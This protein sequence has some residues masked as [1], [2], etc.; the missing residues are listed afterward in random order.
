MSDQHTCPN[1]NVS[2]QTCHNCHKPTSHFGF[3]SQNQPVCYDC[4]GVEDEKYMRKN[5]IHGSLYL[6][7]DGKVCNWPNTLSF[8]VEYQRIGTHNWGCVRTDVWFNGPDGH[9]WHGV[10]IG[11][12][13]ICRCKRTR[14]VW[15]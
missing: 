13:E 11:D 5:G 8:P 4:C 1:C 9:V 10:N 7:N 2:I 6:T 15:K 14:R 3:N 12:N